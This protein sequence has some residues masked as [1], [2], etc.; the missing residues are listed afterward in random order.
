MK[1][2]F[3]RSFKNAGALCLKKPHHIVNIYNHLIQGV[4]GQANYVFSHILKA[5]CKNS[6]TLQS[7]KVIFYT[8]FLTGKVVLWCF[9]S[10]CGRSEKIHNSTVQV[11]N[12]SIERNF[13]KMRWKSNQN[14]TPSFPQN[15]EKV[16]SCACIIAQVG[17]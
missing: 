9:F 16:R 4:K 8:E 3:T 5:L 17:Y 12:L 11:K 13:F 2:F 14:I 7:G 15:L 10:Q 6:M 1:C